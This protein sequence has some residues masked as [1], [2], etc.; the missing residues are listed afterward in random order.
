MVG[1]AVPADNAGSVNGEHHMERIY[2]SVM[3]YLVIGALEEGRIYRKNGLHPP[4]GKSRRKGYGVLLRNSHIKKALRIL[5]GEGFQPCSVGHSSGYGADFTII[6]RHI[7]DNFA[8]RI[9]KTFLVCFDKIAILF[10][11]R[12]NAMEL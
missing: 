7:A 9:G 3:Y 5:L 1:F 12:R 10:I 4:C 11:E 2:G 6:F 8:E